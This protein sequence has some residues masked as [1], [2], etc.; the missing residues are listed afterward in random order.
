MF[1]QS[2]LR[3]CSHRPWNFLIFLASLSISDLSQAS[4]TEGQKI[5]PVYGAGPSTKIVTLFF[6]HFSDR[7]ESAGVKFVVPKRSTKHAGGIRASSQYLFGR[8][9]RPLSRQERAQNKSELFLGRVPVG[10]ATSPTVS[11]PPLDPSDIERIFSGQ[12]SNWKDFGGPD[13][14]I[15]LVGREKTEAV[16]MAMSEHFPVL[17]NANYHKTLRRDHAVVNFLKSPA[18][19]YSIGYGAISNFE[20]L[21]TVEVEGTS[22]GVNVGLVVDNNNLNNPLVRAVEQYAYG[23]E[24]RQRVL[25]EG[26]L[27]V[28][29]ATIR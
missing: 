29:N 5:E 13:A 8:T 26:Y 7:P 3:P 22:L 25:K 15:V 1:M 9:G 24:W 23:D 6:E 2:I 11:L 12:A 19:R 16:L 17:R 28:E 10:F 4:S 21:N 20:S 27:A 14:P 18:G